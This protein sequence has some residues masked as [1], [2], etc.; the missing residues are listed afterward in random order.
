MNVIACV[1]RNEEV[2]LKSSSGGVFSLL[3]EKI[4]EKSNK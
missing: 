4:I 2:R 1:N 3:A